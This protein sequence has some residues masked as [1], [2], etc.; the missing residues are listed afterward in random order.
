MIQRINKNDWEVPNEVKKKKKKRNSKWTQ[1]F[2]I[3]MKK[4]KREKPELS[5]EKKKKLAVTLWVKWGLRTDPEFSNVGKICDH[6]IINFFA[7]V[8]MRAQLEKL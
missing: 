2:E 8:D 6:K 7:K 5:K 1:S 3:Q 4:V